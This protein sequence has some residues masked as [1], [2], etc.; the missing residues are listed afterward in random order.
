MDS[1]AYTLLDPDATHVAIAS[2]EAHYPTVPPFHPAESFP[3]YPFAGLE[4][5]AEGPN[6]AYRLV[7]EA[8][9]LLGLDAERFGHRAWNPLGGYVRPGDTVVIKPNFVRH[10]RETRSGDG[11]CLITHGAVLRA[12]TDYVYIALQGRGRLIIADAPQNDADFAAIRQITGLDAIQAFYRTTGCFPLETYDLRP[13]RARKVDGV[14][15]GHMPLRGDPAGYA[16]V[17]LGSA[18][19][20]AAIEGLCHLLYGSEYD[21]GELVRH[22]SGG[23]HE[24]LVSRTVLDADCVISVPKLKTHKK[25]AMTVNLKNLVGINGNKNWLPHH[26]EGPPS[27]GGDAFAENTPRR[28]LERR[29]V[30]RFKRVFPW[31]GPL[32]PLVAGP[33]KAMGKRVFGDTNEGT[34]RSGNWHGNDTTWR[35]VIDL[36]RLLH[37]A[38]EDGALRDRPV[39]RFF[40]FVDGIVAGEGNGPLDPTP[41]GAG[42]VLAGGNPVAVDLACARLMGFDYQRIPM[43]REALAE[44]S[45]PLADFTYEEIEAL[46][47]DERLRGRL[48]DWRGHLLGFEPHFGWQHYVELHDHEA[49]TIA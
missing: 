2:G 24:Y 1:D 16:K 13:E 36:N 34:I 33:V 29:F 47:E 20:F 21:T 49:G 7:R 26:R 40:S 18:S 45:L 23:V 44:H 6:E 30:Q 12:V 38:D 27:E 4:D 35:M 42:V 25:V 10:F 19:A 31:L 28:R 41:R 3:E 5:I 43:L 22:H 14:I 15:V 48:A 32:R 8:L 17:D 46:S 39:R 11:D 9:R 37:Y